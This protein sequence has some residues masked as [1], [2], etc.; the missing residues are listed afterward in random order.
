MT[1]TKQF[2][3]NPNG[4]LWTKAITHWKRS[5]PHLGTEVRNAKGFG[6]EKWITR[7]C[8]KDIS[9][10]RVCRHNK[11]DVDKY[12]LL[13]ACFK[14][15]SNTGKNRPQAFPGLEKVP[16]G[17]ENGKLRSFLNHCFCFDIFTSSQ[18]SELNEHL[19]CCSA[20]FDRLCRA[21]AARNWRRDVPIKSD[22]F[23]I[24]WFFQ[25]HSLTMFFSVWCKKAHL[26]FASD[27][28]DW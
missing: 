20:A 23:M 2:S 3:L 22:I 18:H 10:L 11:L 5:H 16:L 28:H 26:C 7:R 21:S 4:S 8:P 24:N 13:N 14:Q 12:T 17:I 27:K 6:D 15:P 1:L 25:L 9:L 19:T